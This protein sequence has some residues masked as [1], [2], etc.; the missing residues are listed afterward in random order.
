MANRV[1][2]A[3]SNPLAVDAALRLAQDGGNAVDA[4]LAAILVAMVCEPGIC[5][6]AGGAFVMVAPADGSAAVTVDGNVEMPGRG[7]PPEVFGRG[8]REVTTSYGGGLT[9]HI[10]HASVATPGA[11]AALDAASRAYGR[12]PW[13][14]IVAPAVAAARDGFPLGSASAYYLG[15]VHDSVYDWHPGSQ[16]ALYDAGEL[17]QAGDIMVVEHLADSLQLI[18]EEGAAALYT[19]DLAA[20]IAADMAEYGGLLTA[21]DLAA[22]RPVVRPALTVAYADWVFATNPPPSIGGTALAAMLTLMAELPADDLA[23]LAAVQDGVLGYRLAHLDVTEDRAAAAY[24]LLDLVG[25]G[26]L[27]SLGGA[28]ST[29]HVSV[30][31]AEGGACAVTSSAGY[32]SGVMTPGTGLWLNNCL[33]EPELNRGGG[34]ALDPGERLPSNMAPTVGRT[35]AGDVLAIGSPG[36]DRITTALL[37]VLVGFAGAG[38]DLDAAIARPRL[39]VTRQNETT[40]VQYEDDLTLPDLP[41]P[42]RSHGPASMYF[43]GVGAALRTAAGDLHA[44][45]DPRRNSA[46]AVGPD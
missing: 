26:G 37:Q 14:E 17:R 20:R 7:L 36:A 8:L 4:G 18:A 40:L 28:A 25:S 13:R 44:A 30:V 27:A 16:A 23:A 46:A 42:A 39:H 41:W 38:L 43:G 35:T 33:G 1:A 22:F 29:V 10:G 12:A 34:H 21:A 11:L 2:V 9:M 31:D 45:G 5:S 19:G 15:M 24:R 3:A 32:G 6:P